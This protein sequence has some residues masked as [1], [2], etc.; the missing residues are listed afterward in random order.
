MKKKIASQV[1]Y[2]CYK[3]NAYNEINICYAYQLSVNP[4]E[5]FL[6]IHLLKFI[7]T[8]LLENLKEQISKNI[9]FISCC[10]TLIKLK[11]NILLLPLPDDTMTMVIKQ[12]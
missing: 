3:S 1:S 4:I 11:N 8:I 9:N 7:F 10:K 2:M 5:R 6:F 12:F